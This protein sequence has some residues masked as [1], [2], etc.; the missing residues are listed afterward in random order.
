MSLSREEI[1][2]ELDL[3]YNGLPS[4]YYPKKKEKEIQYNSFLDLEHGYFETAKS[5]IH[6]YADE[7]N[8]AIVFEKNGYS[9]TAYDASIQLSYIGNCIKYFISSYK[10]RCYIS[11]YKF[12]SLITEEEY[13]RIRDK[14][15]ID[16]NLENL[17]SPD[18]KEIQIRTTMNAVDL[19]P[20]KFA[21]LG[22]EPREYN[23]PLKLVGFG[24]LVRFLGDTQPEKIY[25]T[26]EDIR[27]Q[28]S[29]EPKKIMTVDDFHH[30]SIYKQDKLPSQVET[31]QLIADVLINKDAS[32]W[33]PR[34]EANN[35]WSNWE[36]GHL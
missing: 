2:N 25:A 21:E 6:L 5:R 28:F 23:N 22:I 15:G 11:N 8:W 17:I 26:E 20:A 1:L 31:Y 3:A 9:I 36:S 10:G 33:N 7:N 34:L 4:T 12:I 35:H 13:G 18:V 32:L 29:K 14:S 24:D 19:S 30:L 27:P 16:M